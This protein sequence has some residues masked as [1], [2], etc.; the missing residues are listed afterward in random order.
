LLAILAITIPGIGA[1][2]TPAVK[3]NR[4]N[5]ELASQWMPAKVGKLV[6]DLS[7]TPHWLDSGDRFWYSFESS[8]GRRFYLVDPVKKTKSQ[9]FD[10]VKLAASLTQATGLPHDSLHLPITVIR[11]VK[12]ETAIQFEINVKREAVIPGEK[13]GTALTGRGGGETTTQQNQEEFDGPQQQQGGRGGGRFAPPPGRD[14][15]QLTFEYELATGRLQLLEER[16]LRKPAWASVDR[17]HRVWR[18]RGRRRAGATT[19]AGAAGER[20]GGSG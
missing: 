3:H 12:A 8:K 16:P 5:Y 2:A 6:F 9:V 20:R 13:S 17:G 7:V 4:A 10:P 15:K 19:A 1:D 18:A 14:Q 11:F